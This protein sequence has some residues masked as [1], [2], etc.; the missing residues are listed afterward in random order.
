M[1]WRVMPWQCTSGPLKL[2]SPQNSMI[3]TTSTSRGQLKFMGLHTP[4]ASMRRP[5]RSVSSPSAVLCT[6]LYVLSPRSGYL[7]LVC[8]GWC[9][10]FG[11]RIWFSSLEITTLSLL[12]I[13]FWCPFSGSVRWACPGDV[14]SVCRHGMQA[15]RNRPSSCN[16]LLLLT[17]MRSPSKCPP[18]LTHMEISQIHGWQGLRFPW[19]TYSSFCVGGF[20]NTSFSFSPKT[21]SSLAMNSNMFCD[22]KSDTKTHYSKRGLWF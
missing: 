19:S 17:D 8:K 10:P 22:G 3:C 15:W 14:P 2:C 9:L 5:L 21:S 12:T 18:L 16:L 6:C 11:G 4:V 13:Y 7:T 20:R 1:V